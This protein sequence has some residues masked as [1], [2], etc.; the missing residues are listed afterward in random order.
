[1]KLSELKSCAVCNGKIAPLWYVVRVSQ[2]MLNPRAANQTL[3]LMQMFGGNL[4]LAEIMSP[5]PDCVLVMGDKEPSLMTE[6]NI[7]QNCFLMKPLHMG[8]LME[9]SRE[10]EPTHAD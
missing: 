10:P 7:C 2:A 9:S 8:L 6:I 3:G 5:E 1:M 4:A